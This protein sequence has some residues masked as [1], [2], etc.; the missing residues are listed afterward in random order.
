MKKSILQFCAFVLAMLISFTC[1]PG[2]TART[3]A[4]PVTAD[5]GVTITSDDFEVKEASQAYW[6]DPCN[7]L[8]EGDNHYMQIS[9]NGLLTIL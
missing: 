6:S 4:Q 8:T 9:K 5:D 3:Y 1:V 2:F 7:Y